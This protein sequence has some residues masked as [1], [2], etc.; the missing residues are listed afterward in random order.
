MKADIMGLLRNRKGAWSLL[1]CSHAMQN[2]T[3]T[4]YLRLTEPEQN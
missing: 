1:E 2:G 3:P 4:W